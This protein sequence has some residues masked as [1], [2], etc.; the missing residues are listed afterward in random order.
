MCRRLTALLGAACVV[1]VFAAETSPAVAAER[2]NVVI[3]V[4]DDVGG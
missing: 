2:P 3:I 1:S 4:T